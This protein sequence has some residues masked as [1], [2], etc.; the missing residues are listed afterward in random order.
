MN[1]KKPIQLHS[2]IKPTYIRILSN[3]HILTVLISI[4]ISSSALLLTKLE[5]SERNY[6]LRVS[7][8]RRLVYSYTDS[9]LYPII[10]AFMAS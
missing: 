9:P 10:Y 4:K 8:T 7:P 5:F 1:L 2:E 6:L 3:V